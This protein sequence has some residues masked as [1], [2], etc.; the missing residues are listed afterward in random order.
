NP[1]CYFSFLKLPF[2]FNRSV[3]NHSRQLIS[4]KP[5]AS[6]HRFLGGCLQNPLI[7]HSL[8][9]FTCELPVICA[10]DK[11]FWKIV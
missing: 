3:F 8:A 1:S 5:H 7:K 4:S 2:D 11:S 6:L 10:N 9:A